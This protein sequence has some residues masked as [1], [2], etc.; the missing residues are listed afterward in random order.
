LTI[1]ELFAHSIVGKESSGLATTVHAIE[2]AVTEVASNI[3]LLTSTIGGVPE[4]H[5]GRVLLRWNPKFIE[6]SESDARHSFVA[7]Y[8]ITLLTIEELVAS[9]AMELAVNL[10]PEDVENLRQRAPAAL[11]NRI[12]QVSSGE[13]GA[14]VGS[15]LTPTLQEFG[16][17]AQGINAF[18]MQGPKSNTDAGRAIPVFATSLYEFLMAIKHRSQ[19]DI[20]LHSF[21]TA[22]ETI[23]ANSTN[24][25]A[26][27]NLAVVE[28]ILRCYQPRKLDSIQL[29]PMASQRA[30]ELFSEFVNEHSYQRLSEEAHKLGFPDQLLESEREFSGAAREFVH[31]PQYQGTTAM[32]QLLISAATRYPDNSE[33]LP[34]NYLPPIVSFASA[35]QKAQQSYEL[36]KPQ[37]ILPKR[38]E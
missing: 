36:L 6:R 19:A 5:Y 13:V 4:S 38:F 9:G 29:K 18:L 16:I 28:N 23:R 31:S 8:S 12:I 34:G 2:S 32:G 3:S 37:P 17:E 14:I 35:R 21:L 11:R 26:R 30:I 33:F 25:D 10:A 22:A 15:I 1:Q 7:D 20:D 24:V 27:A